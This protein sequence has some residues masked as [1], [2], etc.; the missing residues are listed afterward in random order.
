M[1]GLPLLARSVIVPRG[2]SFCTCLLLEVRETLLS[3][4]SQWLLISS[5]EPF[6]KHSVIFRKSLVKL[7]KV[8]V[9][10]SLDG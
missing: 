1:N 10:L 2:T 5:R 4:S 8:K 7:C 3:R 6:K 9:L